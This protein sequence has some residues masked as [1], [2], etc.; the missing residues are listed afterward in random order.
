VLEKYSAYSIFYTDLFK[1]KRVKISQIKHAEMLVVIFAICSQRGR[2]LKRKR[3]TMVGAILADSLPCRF[4]KKSHTPKSFISE[5]ILRREQK[6]T[7]STS[8]CSWDS[9]RK[10][11]DRDNG[12]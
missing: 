3:Q 5:S 6:L 4:S 10:R 7:P 12:V 1:F 9:C 8:S 11:C 2:S